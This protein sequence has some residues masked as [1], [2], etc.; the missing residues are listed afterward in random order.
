MRFAAD[1][2]IQKITAG[3]DLLQ[4]DQRCRAGI[5]EG[6]ISIAGNLFV[7]L[8]KALFAFFTNSIALLADA[9]HSA[10]DIF[11][12]IVVLIGFSV[13]GKQPDCEHPHGHGRSEYLAALFIGTLL[14][15]TAFY[16]FYCAYDRLTGALF[17]RPSILSI[18]A[19][20]LSILIKE[21]LFHFSNRLGKLINSEALAGDAWHHRSDSLSSI[22]VLVALVGGYLGMPALDSYFGF[23]VAAFILYAGIG[24]FSQSASRLLGRAG[25]KKM[26]DEIASCAEDIEGVIETHDLTI[27]DYGSWKVVTMHIGVEGSLSL[28]KAHEIARKVEETISTRYHCDILVHLDPR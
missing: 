5:I 28:E 13:A 12:S 9:V 24:I 6:W 4:P 16:F 11:S 7:T 22:L 23:A 10:S 3:R 18:T 17:A 14:M 19:V 1:L 27:H 2:L 20:L 8:L 21:F 26:Q 15:I 25:D